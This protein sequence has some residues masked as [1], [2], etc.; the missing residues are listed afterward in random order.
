MLIKRTEIV[1]SRMAA[2]CRQE[3]RSPS[4]ARPSKALAASI[5]PVWTVALMATPTT[6]MAHTHRT[7][8]TCVIRPMANSASNSLVGGKAR[9]PRAACQSRYT[10]KTATLTDACTQLIHAES[11]CLDTSL[12]QTLNAV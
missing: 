12:R 5:T 1:I 11:Y 7:L 10:P 8:P 4:T 6:L 2:I 3:T 9:R